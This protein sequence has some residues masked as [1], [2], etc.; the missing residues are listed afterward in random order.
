[1]ME[2][3][4]VHASM[5]VHLNGTNLSGGD[6]TVK[7]IDK[8]ADLCEL[9]SANPMLGKS[10]EHLTIDRRFIEA[11]EKL[12]VV[13]APLGFFPVESSAKAIGYETY[14]GHSFLA[15]VSG[16]VGPGD[17]GAP[18]LDVYGSVVGVVVMG[19]DFIFLAVPA[20]QLDAFLRR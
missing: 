12:T 9:E 11:K 3:G 2:A 5:T 14:N 16:E 13:G 6:Y 17:S 4:N 15:A 10:V 1:M 8:N 18:V 20:Y 7:A 19:E